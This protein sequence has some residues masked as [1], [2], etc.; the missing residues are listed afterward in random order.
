MPY[1]NKS[2]KTRNASAY[3]R[4]N[5]REIIEKV[6]ISRQERKRK[7]VAYKGGRCFDCGGEFPDICFDFD[8]RDVG[9]KSFQISKRIGYSLTNL[10]IEVDKCDLVCANCHRI[11]TATNPEV[12]AKIKSRM[13]EEGWY[14][15][16]AK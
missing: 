5:M 9:R 7:L 10:L 8:H 14:A 6:Q 15:P 13:K 2:D 1:K 3:Y 11:R 4:E 16:A 12:S